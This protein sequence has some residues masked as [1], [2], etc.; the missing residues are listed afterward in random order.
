MEKF[1][2]SHVESK[3]V[4]DDC[5]GVVLGGGSL[6]SLMAQAQTRQEARQLS[7]AM[8]LN[9]QPKRVLGTPKLLLR[10]PDTA[11]PGL[12]MSQAHYHSVFGSYVK[13]Y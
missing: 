3:S 12:D 7:V 4:W 8:L 2:W 6:D 5:W 13:F 10:T 11:S 1:I 9:K